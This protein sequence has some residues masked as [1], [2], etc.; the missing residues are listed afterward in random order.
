[1]KQ[2]STSAAVAA[3]VASLSAS[4]AP[5]PAKS[6]TLP[7]TVMESNTHVGVSSALTFELPG[8]QIFLPLEEATDY[9]SGLNAN[10]RSLLSIIVQ[11]RQLRGK[12]PLLMID[13]AQTRRVCED[14]LKQH[15][16][17]KEAIKIVISPDNLAKLHPDS[18]ELRVQQRDALI[19]FGRAV[20]QSEFLARDILNAIERSRPPAKTVSLNDMPSDEDVRAMIT[21]EHKSLGLSRPGFS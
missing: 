5:V 6:T 12:G 13:L 16:R 18:L 15:A 8:G 3:I 14:S 17:I 10:Q 11:K 20:A 2:K 7:T 19:R 21:A 9:L 4:L 1:M